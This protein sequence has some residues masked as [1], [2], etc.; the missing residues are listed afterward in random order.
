MP[1]FRPYASMTQEDVDDCARDI[2]RH[3]AWSTK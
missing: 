1:E 3:G 2:D